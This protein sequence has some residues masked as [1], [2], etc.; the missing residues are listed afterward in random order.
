MPRCV[1]YKMPVPGAEAVVTALRATEKPTDA[2]SPYHAF[3]RCPPTAL[4]GALRYPLCAN[5][6]PLTRC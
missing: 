1:W 5:A 3:S 6:T 2:K 4:F